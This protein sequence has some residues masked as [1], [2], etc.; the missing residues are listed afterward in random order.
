MSDLYDRDF[1]LWTEEQATA[2]RRSKGANLPLDWENLAEEIESLGKSQRREL[3]AQIRRALR[4]L[5]K[6]E[7]SPV[8]DPRAGWRGSIQEARADIEDVLTESPSLRREVDALIAKQTRIAAELAAADLAQHS[9]SPEAVW[10]RVAAGGFTA[11]QVLGDW[12]PD[13]AP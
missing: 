1:L 10:A 6:L 2:L 7:A 3:G 13:A 8:S 9:Q 4:H 12:F 11:D 5:Y